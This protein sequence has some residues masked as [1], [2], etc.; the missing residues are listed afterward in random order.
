MA[1][2]KSCTKLTWG[3]AKNK[4][5]VGKNKAV[6]KPH[7]KESHGKFLAAKI[8]SKGGPDQGEKIKNRQAAKLA[9][10]DQ[11]L[12]EELDMQ[13]EIKKE[14]QRLE[15]VVRPHE[16]AL[17][18]MKEVELNFHQRNNNNVNQIN[19]DDCSNNHDKNDDDDDD[20]DR[21]T[22]LCESK[23]LQLDEVL[24]LQAI[25][26]DTETLKI[27]EASNLEELQNK[28]DDWQMDPDRI[29]LQKTVIDHPM[30]ALTMNRSIEDEENNDLIAHI[31]LHIIYQNNY[32][33]QVP[34]IQI[35]WFLV[36]KK[37]A[38]TS[39]NKPLESLGVLDEV[40]LIKS[41]SDHANEYLLGMP[42]V[43]ELLDTWLSEHLSEFINYPSR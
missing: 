4:S 7:Q 27:S 17:Q 14:Q 19:Y 9:K 3:E 6:I 5:G 8:I 30:I 15:D 38:V 12:Q 29:S 39:S 41:M 22:L 31:L 13:R 43:Y 34:T 28:L 23:Q 11:K 16:K 24:A 26:V 35:L 32:P 42:S 21:R 18:K 36:T 2:R 40:E 20:D 25:Y 37:S 1:A 33:L 10:K